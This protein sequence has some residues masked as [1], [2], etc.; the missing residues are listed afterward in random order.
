MTKKEI[1]EEAV[2]RPVVASIRLT[3]DLAQTMRETAAK[4][5][6]TATDIVETLMRGLQAGEGIGKAYSKAKTAELE[7]TAGE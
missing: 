3:G 5:G 6:I 4:F 2:V 7:R 1:A